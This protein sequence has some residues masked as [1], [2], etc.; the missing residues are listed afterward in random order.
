VA[1]AGEVTASRTIETGDADRAANM[2]VFAR[3][4]LLLLDET[5]RAHGEA[6]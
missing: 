2:N 3:Q 4:L 6:G 1:V 5:L